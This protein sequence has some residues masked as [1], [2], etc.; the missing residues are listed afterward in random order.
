MGKIIGP[1]E[2][3]SKRRRETWLLIRDLREN[4]KIRKADN[5]NDRFSNAIQKEDSY[6]KEQLK[7][8]VGIA[9]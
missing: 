6:A 4:V 2:W 8:Y 9:A 3:S 7:V 1:I 5:D